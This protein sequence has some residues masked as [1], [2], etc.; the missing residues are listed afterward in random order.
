M[1]RKNRQKKLGILLNE[2]NE[3]KPI[4]REVIRYVG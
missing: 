4:K 1:E 2:N 3:L